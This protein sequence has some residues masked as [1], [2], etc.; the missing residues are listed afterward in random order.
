MSYE[1]RGD[2]SAYFSCVFES[3][4]SR[5][6]FFSTF[7]PNGRENRKTPIAHLHF[8]VV[9]KTLITP[10][11]VPEFWGLLATAGGGLTQIKMPD[12]CEMTQDG[13]NAFAHRLIWAKPRGT[14]QHKGEIPKQLR[15]PEL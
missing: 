14:L 15:I 10:E 9:P 2:F 5:S 13:L 11:E 1:V 12:Y 3:K 8:I 4:V 7:G 6:D